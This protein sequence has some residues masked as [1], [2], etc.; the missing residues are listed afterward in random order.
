MNYK[1]G[2]ESVLFIENEG[3]PGEKLLLLTFK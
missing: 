3:A 2:R 1:I